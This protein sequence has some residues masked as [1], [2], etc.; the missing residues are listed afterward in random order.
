MDSS[1]LEA[2]EVL[3]TPE[4]ASIKKDYSYSI[5]ANYAWVTTSIGDLLVPQDDIKRAIEMPKIFN[6]DLGI[7]LVPLLIKKTAIYR[8]KVYIKNNSKK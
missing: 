5:I 7:L 1:N 3:K 6:K 8:G 4:K 2:S